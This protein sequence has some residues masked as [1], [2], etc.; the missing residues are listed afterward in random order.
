[1]ALFGRELGR[2]DDLV[3]DK[4][5]AV[6]AQVVD[7]HSFARYDVDKACKRARRREWAREWRRRQV[8]AH[9]AV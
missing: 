7:G 3:F 9:L 8:R 1:V 4:E 2:Q 6:A 5:V